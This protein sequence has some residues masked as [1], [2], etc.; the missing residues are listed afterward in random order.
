MNTF[1][2]RIKIAFG[3]SRKLHDLQPNSDQINNIIFRIKQ[4]FSQSEIDAMDAKQFMRQ[5][6]RV[7]PIA[8]Y[9]D[10]K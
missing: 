4:V 9:I 10:R 3:D 5:V 1:E 6:E 7:W 8:R 2:T